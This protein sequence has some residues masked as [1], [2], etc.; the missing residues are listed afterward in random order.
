M[1]VANSSYHPLYK[2]PEYPRN[3]LKTVLKYVSKK[4]IKYACGTSL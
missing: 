2:T 4:S 3:P 1:F